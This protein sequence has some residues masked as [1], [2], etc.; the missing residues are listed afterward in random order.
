MVLDLT[1]LLLSIYLNAYPWDS[2]L[3]P[4]SGTKGKKHAWRACYETINGVFRKTNKSPPKKTIARKLETTE[5][6]VK[7]IYVRRFWGKNYTPFNVGLPG[8]FS[9]KKLLKKNFVN[10]EPIS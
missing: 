10:R 4:F 9:L 6:Q 5:K 7:R 2:P 1:S 8:W 3:I